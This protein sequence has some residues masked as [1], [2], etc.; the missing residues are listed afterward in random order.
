MRQKQAQN[1]IA[2]FLTPSGDKFI[3]LG[4]SLTEELQNQLP[5]NSGNELLTHAQDLACEAVRDSWEAYQKYD[6][7]EFLTRTVSML[8][9]SLY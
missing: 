3:P 7:D 4:E 8:P 2:T 5:V 9:L 6:R 1:I